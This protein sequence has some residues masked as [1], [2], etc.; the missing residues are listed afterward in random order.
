MIYQ[1][2]NQRCKIFTQADIYALKTVDR[3][4]LKSGKL[5]LPNLETSPKEKAALE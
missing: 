1:L 2:K 5:C 3:R 4:R